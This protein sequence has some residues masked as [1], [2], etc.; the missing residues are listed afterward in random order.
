MDKR[1][2]PADEGPEASEPTPRDIFQGRTLEEIQELSADFGALLNL[3]QVLIDHGI[4]ASFSISDIPHAQEVLPKVIQKFGINK[5]IEHAETHVTYNDGQLGTIV[6]GLVVAHIAGTMGNGLRRLCLTKLEELKPR[7]EKYPESGYAK[8][9]NELPNALK[10]LG[11][12]LEENR[13]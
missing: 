12:S 1:L 13:E 10:Q 11:I 4:F 5:L 9:I 7:A 3:Q 6:L 8:Q 2:F